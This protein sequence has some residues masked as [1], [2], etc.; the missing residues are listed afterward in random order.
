MGWRKEGRPCG[1]RGHGCSFCPR[2]ALPLFKAIRRVTTREKTDVIKKLLVAKVTGT[3]S[4]HLRG[5][6][7]RGEGRRGACAAGIERG[8]RGGEALKR[9]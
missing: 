2:V 7:Q 8:C 6:G 9:P 1:G 3:K 5:A 4:L